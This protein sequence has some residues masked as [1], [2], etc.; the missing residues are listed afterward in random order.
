MA[1]EFSGSPDVLEMIVGV[2]AGFSDLHI[3][4]QVG[5]KNHTQVSHWRHMCDLILTHM[6]EWYVYALELLFTSYNQEFWF[7]VV[8][9]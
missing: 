6:N 8:H 3:H 5:V 4:F 9:H 1:H 2:L 7:A